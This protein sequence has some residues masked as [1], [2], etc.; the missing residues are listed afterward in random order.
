MSHT[1]TDCH[2]D[3]VLTIANVSNFV[4]LARGR[5]GPATEIYVLREDYDNIES[6]ARIYGP[7]SLAHQEDSQG[8]YTQFHGIRWRPKGPEIVLDCTHSLKEILFFGSDGV[9]LR[10]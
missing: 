1:V 4:S 5:F 10:P 9:T 2:V 3:K 6:L 7:D 8:V